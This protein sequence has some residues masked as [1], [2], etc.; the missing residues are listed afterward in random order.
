MSSFSDAGIMSSVRR[1][2]PSL[3]RR[4]DAAGLRAQAV[5]Q[6]PG[7]VARQSAR[8]WPRSATARCTS[9]ADTK[10]RRPGS[11]PRSKEHK[12]CAAPEHESEL[13]D[14]RR[15]SLRASAIQLPDLRFAQEKRASPRVS[16]AAGLGQ[17]GLRVRQRV[18]DGQAGG[19]RGGRLR[20]LGVAPRAERAAA[21]CRRAR[22]S[23][24]DS[25]VLHSAAG[26]G[27]GVGGRGWRRRQA[28]AWHRCEWAAQPRATQPSVA[29]ES[30]APDM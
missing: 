2:V 28:W 15:A 9:A 19:R 21:R 6:W 20:S 5:R 29:Q 3:R 27:A 26:V 12:R 10:H 16:G 24:R 8:R 22:C 1:I 23:C 7:K 11:S 30:V 14:P 13:E 4:S 25:L 17:R 18:A